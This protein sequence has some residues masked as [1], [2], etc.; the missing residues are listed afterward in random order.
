MIF[1][2][3]LNTKIEDVKNLDTSDLLVIVRAFE[4]GQ[5]NDFN[6]NIFPAVVDELYNRGIMCIW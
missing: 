4:D 5:K 6:K 3:I 2:R 1:G